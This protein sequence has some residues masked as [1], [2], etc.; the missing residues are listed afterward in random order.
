MKKDG[1]DELRNPD[2]AAKQLGVSASHLSLRRQRRLPPQ[3]LKIGNRVFYR[4]KDLQAFIE[5]SLVKLGENA[6]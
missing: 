3:Y 1:I 4:V 2:Q 5:Q 6:A